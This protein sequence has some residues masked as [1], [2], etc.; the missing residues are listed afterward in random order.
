MEDRD[1]HL[2]ACAL[3]GSALDHGAKLLLLMDLGLAF[4]TSM[5]W[6][7]I[8][9]ATSGFLESP[10]L[11]LDLGTSHHWK[12]YHLLYSPELGT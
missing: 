6:S 9:G 1:P 10:P 3:D 8:S 12:L 4:R 7:F 11:P 2:D 5:T